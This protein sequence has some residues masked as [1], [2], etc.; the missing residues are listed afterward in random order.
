MRG[1]LL[2]MSDATPGDDDA[3]NSL[4]ARHHPRVFRVV[5]GI[6]GDFHRSEDVCQDVFATL[7]KCAGI[8]AQQGCQCVRMDSKDLTRGTMWVVP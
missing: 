2:V 1:I 6:L 8:D 7:Y 5:R 4:V 3:F